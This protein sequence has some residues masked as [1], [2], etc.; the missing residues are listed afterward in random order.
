MMDMIWPVRDAG[1]YISV[2]AEKIKTC[3][4]DTRRTMY[5]SLRVGYR[6]RIRKAI[7]VRR[8]R[9]LT[10]YLIGNRGSVKI[11]KVEN[12][13]MNIVFYTEH[14]KDGK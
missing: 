2:T 9:N 14:F 4:R 11:F 3:L 10:F 1:N 8:G 7:G 13:M 6:S 5:L 12:G